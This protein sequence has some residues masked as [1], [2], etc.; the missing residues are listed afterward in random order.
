[1]LET[2]T[3]PTA[4]LELGTNTR[5]AEP[6]SP[7]PWTRR[8]R[9]GWIVQVLLIGAYAYTYETIRNAVMGGRFAALHNA[10]VLTSIERTLGLYHERAV[11]HFFLR[12]PPVVAFWNFYYDTAHFLVPLFVAIYLYVKFPARFV[13]YRTVFFL[14]LI[15][16][17]QISWLLFPVT[18]PK[19]MPARYGFVDTQV[20]YWNMGPQQ[21]LSYGPD[22]EPS[23][24]VVA[25]VGNLYGGMPSHHA[26]WAMWSVL[27]L[28]PVVR[29]RRYRALLLAHLM[30]TVGAITVT[31]NHRFLDIAGSAVEVAIALAA[32]LAIERASARRRA[33]RRARGG[34]TL[35]ENVA[36]AL[37]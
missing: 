1:M 13:H 12:W 31:G 22:G 8:L 18:P 6:S 37:P 35:P 10:R 33:R 7:R 29:R 25:S 21:P 30:L 16:V 34:F 32:A 15:G 36:P 17:G 20:E 19:F 23:A 3:T 26:S 11:Q 28:W 24:K 27:A 4:P 2:P 9:H 14:I 5:A